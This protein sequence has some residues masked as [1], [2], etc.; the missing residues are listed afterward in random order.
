MGS[1]PILSAILCVSSTM[2]DYRIA[3]AAV[4]VAFAA[5]ASAQTPPVER[6]FKAQ[7]G[8][9]ARVGVFTNIRPDC[10]SGPLPAIRLSTPPAHG[11]VTVKRGTLKATNFKQCLATEVPAFVAFYRPEAEYKG[12]DEFELEVS[13]PNGRKQIQ[14]FKVNVSDNPNG[15]QGI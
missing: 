6:E 10:T 9:T 5:G 4:C 11:A 2:A 3:M 8:H 14:H 12:A 15:G 13:V 1:N 7:T